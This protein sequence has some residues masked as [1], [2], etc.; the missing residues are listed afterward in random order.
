MDLFIS[1][2]EHEGGTLTVWADPKRWGFTFDDGPDQINSSLS[3]ITKKGFFH[4]KN[5]GL[6]RIY[7]PES[8]VTLLQTQEVERGVSSKAFMSA[9]FLHEAVPF[10]NVSEEIVK[11]LHAKASTQ[12]DSIQ[13]RRLVEESPFKG[14][15]AYLDEFSQ[16]WLDTNNAT[17]AFSDASLLWRP[18]GL[19][20]NTGAWSFYSDQTG[21]QS[22]LETAENSSSGQL[23]I[24]AA[25]KAVQSI[26][27]PVLILADSLEVK[28]ASLGKIN[29]SPYLYEQYMEGRLLVMWVK[30]HSD[31]LGNVLVD[32]EAGRLSAE[33]RVTPGPLGI[34]EM[35]PL[36]NR[37]KRHKDKYR[38]ARSRVTS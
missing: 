22:G 24:L 3:A 11:E 29:R 4:L 38:R 25:E 7:A 26:T 21:L 6:M 5:S 14:P 35:K 28:D 27:G 18:D 12:F 33:L 23:E 37:K 10:H 8:I 19:L 2:F 20:H 16:E 31:C 15:L 9:K 36:V 13:S 30:G 1:A 17:L 34:L 32:A